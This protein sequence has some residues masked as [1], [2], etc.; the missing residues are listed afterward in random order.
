MVSFLSF[1]P[2][3]TIPLAA[4]SND[5]NFFERNKPESSVVGDL[6]DRAVVYS[7]VAVHG[8][9]EHAVKARVESLL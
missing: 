9:R 4:L 5:K 2:S 6:E 1:H 7:Q 3:V 8:W